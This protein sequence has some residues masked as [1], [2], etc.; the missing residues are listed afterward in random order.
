VA[1]GRIIFLMGIASHI[2]CENYPISS[3]G[4][5]Q[6]ILNHLWILDLYDLMSG[7]FSA[8]HMFSMPAR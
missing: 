6:N 4:L 7:D 8:N 3:T 2:V 1:F 5:I